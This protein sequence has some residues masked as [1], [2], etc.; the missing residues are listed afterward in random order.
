MTTEINRL[1][2]VIRE[3]F[4][5]IEEA[6]PS[7][8]TSFAEY[9]YQRA[10]MLDRYALKDF[11]LK[12]LAVGDVVVV[13]IKDDP[14]YPQRGYGVVEAFD[15]VDVTVRLDEYFN[16]GETIVR[17]RS[18]VDKPLEMTQEQISRRVARGVAESEDESVRQYWRDEF[19]ELMALTDLVPAGR[20]DFGAGNI[21]DV[22]WINCFVIPSP[23][24]SLEGIMKHAL[25]NSKIMQ[26]GGGVGSDTST[27]RPRAARVISV[28]GASSGSVSWDNYF[29]SLTHLIQ[30]GG[31]RRGARMISKR[32]THPDVIYFAMCKIQNADRLRQIAEGFADYPTIAET[33]LSLIDSKTGEVIDKNFLTGANISIF[34]PDAFM[35][36]VRDDRDWTFLFPDYESYSPEEKRRYDEEWHLT[37]GDVFKW[38]RQGFALKEYGTLPARVLNG[39]FD[40]C[41]WA[42]A[43]PGA[44]YIDTINRF[45]NAYYYAP[46]I[47]TN[48]CGEQPLP[49]YGMCTLGHTNWSNMHD[50]Q[51]DD[52]AWERLRRAI[53]GGIRF[54]DD[55]IDGSPLPLPE[56]REMAMSER[57]IGLGIMGLADLFIK[58]RL[59]YGSPEMLAKLEQI[60]RFFRDESYIA[61]SD[62]A[63][64]RGS[65][66][67]FDADKYLESGFTKTLPDEIREKIRRDG[68]RNVCTNTVA[69]TG[70]KGTMLGVGT[71]LEPYFAFEYY[72]SGRMGEKV[73]VK[74][75]IAQEWID[76]W[77]AENPDWDVLPPLPPEFV[78]AQDIGVYEHEAVQAVVQRYIDSA[79]SKTCNAP[80]SMT[81]AEVTALNMKAWEDGLKGV[82]VYRD[83]S[84]YEAVLTTSAEVTKDENDGFDTPPVSDDSAMEA[85]QLCSFRVDEGGQL[86]KECS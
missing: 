28:N 59:P 7:D 24:D 74:V 40:F 39:L 35:E 23:A 34:K 47:A 84:R 69:P 53:H 60:M 9:P 11:S 21:A 68:M 25:E 78:S 72:R 22:T 45:S 82:T 42:S 80:N 52:V 46:L 36:A 20:I 56:I 6:R 67:L 55:V 85:T 8:V 12:T 76:H 14:K 61:S 73:Q 54:L 83:G 3:H 27:L 29:A 50:A 63:K 1:N 71:G 31:S 37:G 17:S 5:Y 86:I 65:F 62:L 10:V 51:T 64:E 44:L 2:A 75:A 70:T 77:C 41:A 57:R 58:L 26:K 49:A 30:Q 19:A 18:F 66:P 13:T 4:P 15:D 48:P 43:E 81:V 32:A 16:G 38:E 33:A 79:C